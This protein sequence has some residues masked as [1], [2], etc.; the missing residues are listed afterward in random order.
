MLDICN[1]SIK[2]DGRSKFFINF[3]I[4]S[5]KIEYLWCSFSGGEVDNVE[6][7]MDG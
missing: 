7:T 1:I 2:G 3:Q 5:L 6:V 4:S